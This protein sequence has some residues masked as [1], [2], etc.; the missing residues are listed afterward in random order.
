MFPKALK[1]VPKA[2]KSLNLVTR[3]VEGES[4]YTEIDGARPISETKLVF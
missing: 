3:V 1:S 2:N 4:Q